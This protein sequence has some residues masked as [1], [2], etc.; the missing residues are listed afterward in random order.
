M[1]AIATVAFFLVLLVVA[2]FAQEGQ[3]HG[4]SR[5][6]TVNIINAKGQSVGTAILS[7]SPHGV[8]IDR[9]PNEMDAIGGQ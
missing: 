3:K 1:R 6:V 4:T 8:R 9:V 5:P 2:V 7:E